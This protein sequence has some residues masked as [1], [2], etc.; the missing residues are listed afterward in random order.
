MLK[1]YHPLPTFS[2]TLDLTF[3]LDAAYTGRGIGRQCLERLGADARALGAAHMIP[4]ISSENDGSMRFHERNGFRC[5]R[6]LDNIG[7]K[8]NREFSIVFM[9]K[10]L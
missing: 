1:R 9:Q 6:K 2:K 7:Y 4:L 3:F 5:C 8:L 10:D